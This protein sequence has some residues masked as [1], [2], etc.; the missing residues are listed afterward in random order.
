MKSIAN[1]ILGIILTVSNISETARADDVTLKQLFPNESEEFF[2]WLNNQHRYWATGQ[3]GAFRLGSRILRSYP[4]FIREYH[5]KGAH[6]G[7]E[8]AR[9]TFR[10]LQGEVDFGKFT[11]MTC[12]V[13]STCYRNSY[14]NA[15]T[16]YEHPESCHSKRRRIEYTFVDL[17][18][19]EKGDSTIFVHEASSSVDP[20]FAP[21]FV[22]SFASISDAEFRTTILRPS[23]TWVDV[24]IDRLDGEF[25]QVETTNT[26]KSGERLT[27][28]A[29]LSGYCQLVDESVVRTEHYDSY[30][31]CF[32]VSQTEV[33]T[34]YH[35]VDGASKL[36]V[37]FLDGQE[38]DATLD[39]GSPSTDLAI[40]TVNGETP[41]NLSLAPLR[42]LKVGDAVFTLGFP[43]TTLLGAEPKFTDGTVSSLTGIGGDASYFQMSVP[44][45]P[46]NSGGPVVN[47][48][49]EVVGIVAA[50]AAIEVFLEETGTLPQNVN[51]AS[52]SDFARMLFDP[53]VSSELAKTRDEAIRRTRAALCSVTASQ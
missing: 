45:Q 25:Q 31:T 33:L 51:W 16:S 8:L 40:L 53:I 48:R 24:F 46:G 18:Q 49:G 39:S 12:K 15:R 20:T 19:I 42:S 22:H 38:L 32:S 6:G 7:A 52:K 47:N 9:Q 41:E 34:S 35:V 50:T 43:V 3:T 28:K 29:V 36:K 4:E 5:L 27:E 14:L 1:L 26:Y 21:K 23:G 30:G 10:T 13:E 37:R 2:D 17:Y 44:V 11:Q